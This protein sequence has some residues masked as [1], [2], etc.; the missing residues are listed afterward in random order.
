MGFFGFWEG[1]SFWEGCLKL[2]R[3][4]KPPPPK[5]QAFFQLFFNFFFT[6]FLT[7]FLTCERFFA[8]IPF[9]LNSNEKR[10]SKKALIRE[11]AENTDLFDFPSL[12]RTNITNLIVI[13]DM[14]I[15]ARS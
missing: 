5:C 3:N 14:A 1:G 12:E 7:F 4:F 2:L 13:R 9:M 6:F 15:N 8:I 10:P 11:I